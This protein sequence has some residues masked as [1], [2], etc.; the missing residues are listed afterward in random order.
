MHH[1]YSQHGTAHK[2]KCETQLLCTMARLIF[3]DFHPVPTIETH[4]GIYDLVK[5]FVSMLANGD[6]GNEKGQGVQA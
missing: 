5:Q 2:I 4:H 1:T 3:V 6:V